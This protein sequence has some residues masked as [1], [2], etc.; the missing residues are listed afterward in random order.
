MQ[1]RTCGGKAMPVSRKSREEKKKRLRR[2]AVSC[3]LLLFPPKRD[4][5][6]VIDCQARYPG[7]GL[8]WLLR[9]ALVGGVSGYG[10]G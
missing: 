9:Q 2:A 8:A 1:C 4:Q 5:C 6:L 10:G 3:L 7:S